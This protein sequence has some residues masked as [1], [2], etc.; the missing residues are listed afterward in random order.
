L[1]FIPSRPTGDSG[2]PLLFENTI[3]VGVNSFSSNPCATGGFDVFAN[4]ASSYDFINENAFATS[5]AA[6][7]LYKRLASSFAATSWEFSD[8]QA[9]PAGLA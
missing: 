6:T 7:R 8:S 5:C 9:W 1:V 2:G 3:Q 4:I